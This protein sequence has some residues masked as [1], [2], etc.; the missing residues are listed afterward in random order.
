MANMYEGSRLAIAA[1]AV[2]TSPNGTARNGTTIAAGTVEFSQL[3]LLCTTTIVTG[4]V[5]ATYT[6]QVSDDN[7]TWYTF[8]PQSNTAP[9]TVTA[10]G[11]IV[12]DVHPS[13]QTWRYFRPVATLSGAATAA[14]DTTLVTCKIIKFDEAR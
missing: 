1:L 9:T 4:S 6:V 12:L 13:I 7:S 5:V 11:S 2:A 3:S 14:G 8:R 10:T